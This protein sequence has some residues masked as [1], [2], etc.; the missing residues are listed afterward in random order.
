[1]NEDHVCELGKSEPS[2]EPDTV[3]SAQSETKKAPNEN[4][5]P[6]V[7]GAELSSDP[8][9]DSDPDSG[10][11]PPRT[12]GG[13]LDEL[14]SELNRLKAALAERDAKS[15]RIRREYDEFRTLYPTVA[16]DSL[17]DALWSDVENGIP[18]AAAYALAERRHAH[19]A[20]IARLTNL[21]A[22]QR[23]AGSVQGASDGE[24]SPSEVRA[25][26]PSD[27]RK[28]FSRIMRSMQKWR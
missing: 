16:L 23:S 19:E 26:S 8:L 14:R 2:Q 17:S 1:M 22:K 25:M 21:N 10:T 18:L 12:G 24:L 28:N 15:A 27:V 9:A 4:R 20:E 7:E 6:F 3:L 13:E 11:V 5:E